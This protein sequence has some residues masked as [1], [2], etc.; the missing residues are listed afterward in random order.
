MAEDQPA[1]MDEYGEGADEAGAEEQQQ[2][3]EVEFEDLWYAYCADGSCKFGLTKNMGKYASAEDCCNGVINHLKNPD[4]HGY[5]Q[6]EADELVQAKMDHCCRLWTAED[7]RAEYEREMAKR[8]RVGEGKGK[9]A[10]KGKGGKSG[11]HGKGGKSGKGGYVPE[12]R[13][14]P[15]HEPRE[16]RQFLGQQPIGAAAQVA[17]QANAVQQLLQVVPRGQAASSSAHAFAEMIKK[18]A[19]LAKNAEASCKVCARNAR[20]Q[21]EFFEA[22]AHEMARSWEGLDALIGKR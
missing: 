6:S 7:Q 16:H 14:E 13:H 8:R 12:P 19:E 15:R 17:A 5:E 21:A 9:K 10:G 1:T 18:L 4:V 20:Q 22:Q 11:K 2:E 3:E